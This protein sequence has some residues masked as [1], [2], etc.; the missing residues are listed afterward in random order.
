[1][2][3]DEGND[4]LRAENDLLKQKLIEFERSNEIEYQNLKDKLQNNHEF[5]IEML[6]NNHGNFVECLRQEVNKL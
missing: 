2:A 5:Q 4:L 3:T 1:M 6:K